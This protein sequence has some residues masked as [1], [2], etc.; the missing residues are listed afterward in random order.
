M[1]GVDGA[2]QW[3]SA[4]AFPQNASCVLRA[5]NNISLVIMLN[6]EGRSFR[7]I[8]MYSQYLESVQS[9]DRTL[10]VFT[11]PGLT[12]QATHSVKVVD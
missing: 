2:L 4:F 5:A 8:I 1:A 12:E 6:I 11:R 10:Q 9:A 7:W 3:F